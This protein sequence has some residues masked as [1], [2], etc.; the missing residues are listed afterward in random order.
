MEVDELECVHLTDL[1]SLVPRERLA[2][3]IGRIAP[4][5]I[6]QQPLSIIQSSCR[7]ALQA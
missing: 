7:K 5:L 2:Y 6:E 1:P 3:G 4:G